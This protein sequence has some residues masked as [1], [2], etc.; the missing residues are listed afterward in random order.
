MGA[1]HQ[2]DARGHHGSRMDQSADRGGAG[3]G[4]RQPGVEGDLRRLADRT[5]EQE[6]GGGRGQRAGRNRSHRLLDVEGVELPEQQEE[7]DRKRGVPDPGDDEGLLGGEAVLPI[8]MPESDQQVRA[9]A[10]AL[11]AEIER[12]QAVAQD[13]NEHGAHEQVQVAEEEAVVGIPAH[14]L[15]GIEVDE[16]ADEGDRH[17]HHQGKLI[18]VQAQRNTERT[19]LDP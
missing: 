9:E 8:P 4:V 1:G 11:P 18:Q 7:A 14:G 15:E 2:V 10:H 19:H 5:P 6:Q 17:Q 3:H 12:E 13:Q 16:K